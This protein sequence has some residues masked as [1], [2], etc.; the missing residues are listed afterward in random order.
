MGPTISYSVCDLLARARANKPGEADRLFAQARNYLEVLARTHVE[1]RLQAKVDASDLVQQTL[2]DAHRDFSRFRGQSEGEW[3]AWLKQILHHNAANFVRRFRT[4]KRQIGRETPIA[5]GDDSI[6][7]GAVPEPAGADESPS[8]AVV[9]KE[10]ELLLADALAQLAPD[11]Y[12]VILLRNLQRMP[13]LE[14][15]ERMGRSRPAVQMLWM[16]A[17]GKLQ[18]IL[19]GSQSIV[20]DPEPT[21]PKP[22]GPAT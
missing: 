20:L 8:Q 4:G 10:R 18:E 5:A 22:T 15:A 21:D 13:F 7:R 6:R 17:V 16:R 11:H 19:K 2:L 14:I 9:R 1:R 3:L 12:E